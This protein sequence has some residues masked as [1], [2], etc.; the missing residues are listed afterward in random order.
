MVRALDL[1]DS[2]LMGVPPIPSKARCTRDWFIS[3]QGICPAPE[4]ASGSTDQWVPSALA[5]N[6]GEEPMTDMSS[7]FTLMY[8]SQVEALWTMVISVFKIDGTQFRGGDVGPAL[9]TDLL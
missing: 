9:D 8:I 1:F 6:E 4:G 5:T 3:A 2:A 7:P